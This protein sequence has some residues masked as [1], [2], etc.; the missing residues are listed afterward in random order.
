M[1][2]IV[3]SWQERVM[4]FVRQG[5]SAERPYVKVGY[6][7]HT[8]G[9]REVDNRHRQGDLPTITEHHACNCDYCDRG[10][11]VYVDEDAPETIAARNEGREWAMRAVIELVHLGRLVQEGPSVRL[12]KSTEGES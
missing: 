3:P 2:D 6:I 7:V 9:Q 1:T 8:F 10:E 5:T 4:M 12:P 11:D